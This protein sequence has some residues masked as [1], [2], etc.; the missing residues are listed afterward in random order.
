V[1]DSLDGLNA[2]QAQKFCGCCVRFGKLP[3]VPKQY[4]KK[5]EG[6]D[7]FGRCAPGFGGTPFGCWGP[8]IRAAGHPNER[9]CEEDAKDAGTRDRVGVAAQTGSP[10]P[11]KMI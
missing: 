3:Q 7:R 8:G 6:T 5:L 2:K 4:F 1:E 9:I 11:E 10:E